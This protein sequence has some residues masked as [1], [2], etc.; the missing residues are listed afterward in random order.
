MEI[1]LLGCSMS[2]HKPTLCSINPLERIKKV[3][4]SYLQDQIMWQSQWTKWQNCSIYL[5]NM[6]RTEWSW[7]SPGGRCQWR[8][9]SLD[10][11]DIQ[12]ISAIHIL[13]RIILPGYHTWEIYII[14][15]S[16]LL[17][18]N[19]ETPWTSGHFILQKMNSLVLFQRQ[20]NQ[21]PCQCGGDLDASLEGR[22][23]VVVQ[24]YRENTDGLFMFVNVINLNKSYPRIVVVET[25]LENTHMPWRPHI[26]ATCSK[27]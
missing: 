21:K 16:G 3:A 2:D 25:N 26:F 7:S 18:S 20:R 23:K 22:S 14:Q 10:C 13:S 24:F 17:P 6:S 1:P 4:K 19:H 8:C 12:H 9:V 11:F 5:Q 27:H 15:P